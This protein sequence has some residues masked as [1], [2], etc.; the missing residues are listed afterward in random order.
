MI[1]DPIVE[2]VRQMKEF[3][4]AIKRNVLLEAAKQDDL[5]EFARQLTGLQETA[6]KILSYLPDRDLPED[7]F[8]E[9]KKLL[10]EILQIDAKKKLDKQRI[11]DLEKRVKQLED[12]LR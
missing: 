8:E 9:A 2:S 4:E 11:S 5:S 1:Q 6:K 7:K 3:V 12:L 10:Q